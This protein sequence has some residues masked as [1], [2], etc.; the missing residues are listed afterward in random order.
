MKTDEKIALALQLERLGVDIIEAGF[1]ATSPGDFEAVERIAAVI[2]N[3]SIAGLCRA[4]KA[5]IQTTW[6]AL[7]GAAK[8]RIHIVIATSDIHLETKLKK[9]KDEVL[10]MAVDA[11]TF[12]KT[13][14]DDV[15]FS[16]ED[17]IR[18]NPDYL[19]QVIEAVID[20]GAS[21]VNVPDTVGYTIPAEFE[22]LILYIRSKVPNIERANIS[23]HCH[24]DLGMAVANSLAAIRAGANQ[25]ECTVNGIGERAGNAAL[26]EI[27]MM[28]NVRKDI[29]NDIICKIKTEEI[30]RTSKLLSSI[31]GIECQ[32]NKAIVGKN[33]FSHESGIHQDGVLKNPFTYE[34]MTPASVGFPGNKIVLGK[35]SGRNAFTTRLTDLGHTLDTAAMEELFA[36]FK[37]LADKK[38]EVHDEDL[39]ALVYSRSNVDKV[40]FELEYVCFSSGNKHVPTATVVL[41]TPSGEVITDASTGD[42]PVD[43][44]FRAIER[45]SNVNSRLLKYKINAVTAGKDAQGEVA[46]TV[47]FNETDGISARGY[48]TDV[49]VAS[50]KA[51]INALNRY[52]ARGMK[53]K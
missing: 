46:L 48:S 42:G 17:A 28:L 21:T 18:S 10:R 14:C 20:A 29:F 11:V 25:V 47:S 30:Y 43:A 53:S 19:C 32:P 31:T 41:K 16:A 51:Y 4:N 40:H 5:E 6:N 52:V 22:T 39:D 3:A 50:V 44:A 38:K 1:P 33:A 45:I 36:E 27:V 49:L 2:K 34:I 15:E 23:V 35:H 9:S 8:P 24:N 12:A 37:I 13:L 7:K 26:E